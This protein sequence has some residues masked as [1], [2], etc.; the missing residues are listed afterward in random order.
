M[1]LTATCTKCGIEKD[2][3]EFRK[4]KRGANGRRRDCKN[5]QKHN[6]LNPVSW[7]GKPLY[8]PPYLKS[9]NGDEKWVELTPRKR[10]IIRAEAFKA[11]LVTGLSHQYEDLVQVC[12]IIASRGKYVNAKFELFNYMEQLYGDKEEERFQ[13]TYYIEFS[14]LLPSEHPESSDNLELETE[15][16]SLSNAILELIKKEYWSEK[17]YNHSK[18]PTVYMLTTMYGMTPK[19]IAMVLNISVDLVHRILREVR[20]LIELEISI[21]ELKT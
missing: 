13:T 14:N 10:A 7:A 1:N 8:T 15:G 6:R 12:E 18:N 3:S 4:S 9:L 20:D 16:K 17:T 5:C 21:G 19:E 11:C 2:L